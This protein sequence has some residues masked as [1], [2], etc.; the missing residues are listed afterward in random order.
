MF[1]GAYGELQILHGS[2]GTFKQRF[3]D[4][5]PTSKSM[6]GPGTQIPDASFSYKS[7]RRKLLAFVGLSF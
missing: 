4:V 2:G 6:A 5:D 1:L 3:Y 7:D